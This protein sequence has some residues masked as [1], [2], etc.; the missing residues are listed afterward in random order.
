MDLELLVVSETEEIR[1]VDRQLRL[2]SLPRAM[3]YVDGERRI[4][5]VGETSPEGVTLVKVLNSNQV[6][7][8]SAGKRTTLDLNLSAVFPDA[9]EV[10]V[11][12]AEET[13]KLWAG[14][15]GFFYANG[16]INGY[17]VRFLV[18]TGATI[19]AIDGK[20]ARRIGLDFANAKH[21]IAQTAGG[22]TPM[23]AAKLK[24]VTVGNITLNDIDAGIMVQ[25]DLDTP[26]LGMSFLGQLD[27]VRTS[28]QMELNSRSYGLSEAQ[29]QAF[30]IEP[31]PG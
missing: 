6:V 8:D 24:E 14:P 12:G 10:V 4:L 28:N 26:L 1:R 5:G 15:R 17:P 18:D 31:G 20:L 19:I 23:V 7:V 2:V 3:L 22:T 16:S 21:D 25:S 29:V 11:A 27:M 30:E 9:P 13:T